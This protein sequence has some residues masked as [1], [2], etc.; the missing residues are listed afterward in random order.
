MNNINEKAT[1]FTLNDENG[2]PHSLSD[3]LGKKVVLY[4]YP[5]DNTSG[6]TTQALGFKELYEEFSKENVVIIG[7]SKDSSSSHKKFKEKYDFPFI[8]LSDEITAVINDY[9]VY[10][11][12]SMYGR[13]YMGVVRTTFVINEEGI[14]ISKE[15]KVN[16]KENPY[17]T[18]NIIKNK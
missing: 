6:C 10:Q 12:K 18:L 4:F 11:E 16:A 3:Y 2:V 13:N 1:D 5:K 8:L 15:E 7:I 9:G 14:I 17:C